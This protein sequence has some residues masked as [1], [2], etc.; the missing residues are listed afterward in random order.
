MERCKDVVAEIKEGLSQRS[1]SQK[2]EVRVMRAM[3]NDPTYSVGIYDKSGKIGDYCPFED[4]RSMLGSIINEATGIQPKEAKALANTFEFSN[5]EATSMVNIS[6]EFI[7]TYVETGRKLP[8]GGRENMNA[9]ISIKHVAESKKQ[10]PV[11][12]IGSKER[13]EVIIPAH[14]SL[15]VTAP[16]PVWKKI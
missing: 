9:S 3:L 11:G 14:D 4:S 2:D 10:F 15:K 6:K 8:L 12:G 16:C 1:S 5:K 7:N 13:G